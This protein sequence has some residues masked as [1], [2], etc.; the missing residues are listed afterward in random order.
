MKSD[1]YIFDWANVAFGSKKPI[2]NLDPIFLA[3][4]REVS[5]A[6]FAQLVKEYLPKANLLIGIAKEPYINGFENQ[7]Q[8]RTLDLSMIQTIIDKVNASSPAHKIYTVHYFQRE[9]KHLL[10]KLKMQRVLLINGSWHYAFHTLEPYYILVNRRVSYSMLSPFASEAEA[11]EYEDHVEPETLNQAWPTL[12]L[13]NYNSVEMLDHATSASRLSFDYNFQTGVA[14][15]KKQPRS[16]DSYTFLAYAF[17]KVVPFQTYALHYGA[18][19]ETNFSPP[20]DL[21]H[22][23]T[24]HA[25]VE[26]LIKAQRTRLNLN[27]TTLFINLLPCPACSRMICDTSINEIIYRIDHSDGYAVAM[28]ERAGKTVRREV[29]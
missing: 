9:L 5:P 11:H 8:F 14:L 20:H 26:L 19:R 4:P 22:Y 28:L 12:P 18:S 13:G 29:S 2:N 7:P 21:N 1:P 15:G 3:A 25:E 17:N 27:D 23:D 6:R 24:V 16:A 10:E